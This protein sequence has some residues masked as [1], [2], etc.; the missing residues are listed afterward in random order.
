[1]LKALFRIDFVGW[2]FVTTSSLYPHTGVA[3]YSE[4]SGQVPIG[5]SLQG[6]HIGALN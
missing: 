2:F 3:P 4:T 1:M 6:H 5:V